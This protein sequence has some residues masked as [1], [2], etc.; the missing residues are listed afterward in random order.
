[1]HRIP[2][3]RWPVL[4]VYSIKQ[5]AQWR[6]DFWSGTPHGLVQK[7]K[8][9]RAVLILSVLLILG[10][11]IGL[12]T[13]G[14]SDKN[15]ATEKLYQVIPQSFSAEVLSRGVVKPA[16]VASIVS[17][18]PGNRGTIVWMVGE[19][20]EVKTG[21]VVA[22]FDTKPSEDQLDKTNRDLADTRSDLIDS[23]RK[24]EVREQEQQGALE[25]AQREKEISLL[26]AED[27]R[28]GSSQLELKKLYQTI[29]QAERRLALSEQEVDDFN[30]LFQ[31]G[32]VSARELE[33]TKNER[34]VIAE[35]LS[36]AKAD[37]AN[38]QK[39]VLP[40]KLREAE[41]LSEAAKLEYDR[42]IRTSEAELKKL[43]EAVLLKER[44]VQR[45]EAMVNRAK[46][47]LLHCE[48]KAPI[49]GIVLYKSTKANETER[50]FRVGDRVWAGQAFMELPDNNEL[51]VE[52]FVREIDIA[53]VE[54]GMAVNV[55]LDAM[56]NMVLAGRVESIQR[57]TDNSLAEQQTFRVETKLIN[58]DAKILP[59]LSAQ[60]A[61]VTD[62]RE[63]VLSV[64][65]AAIEYRENEPGVWVKEGSALRWQPVQQGSVGSEWVEI[66][67]GLKQD[68]W[69]SYRAL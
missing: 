55:Q 28:H 21:D 47:E 12:T 18:L 11:V 16:Q 24:L 53:R 66:T 42:V 43:Q 9:P 56:P 35:A 17:N 46:E 48:V 23:K 64:P 6:K 8:T 7:V 58:P 51:I 37:L 31:K 29:E 14:Y 44:E 25:A 30:E 62:S 20:E 68:D 40:R 59:G 19:G 61:I 49:D 39:Y 10:L 4:R 41:L 32:Y 5:L 22:R 67:Q 38:F 65:L 1:M 26:K 57:H 15:A 60:V 2:P 27:I 63:N 33:S 69:I 45:F 13:L 34:L 36:I 52:S 50:K 54:R 3:N